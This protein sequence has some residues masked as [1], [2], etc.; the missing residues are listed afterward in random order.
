METKAQNNIWGKNKHGQIV[1]KDD[2]LQCGIGNDSWIT[3][4]QIDADTKEWHR[5]KD[6]YDGSKIGSYFNNSK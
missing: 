2:M 4:V 5:E 6:Y 3:H 1:K